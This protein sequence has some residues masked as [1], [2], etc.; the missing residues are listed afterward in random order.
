MYILN[1]TTS[2]SK[3]PLNKHILALSVYFGGLGSP[4]KTNDADVK[5]SV[6][7]A[8]NTFAA[9]LNAPFCFFITKASYK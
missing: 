1:K 6:E 9:T 5:M 4:K 7:S 8:T 3:W 2:F